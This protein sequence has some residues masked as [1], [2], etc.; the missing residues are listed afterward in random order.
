MA[1]VDNGLTPIEGE[2]SPRHSSQ[3]YS[4]QETCFC[5]RSSRNFAQR[6]E[7]EKEEIGGNAREPIA[8]ALVNST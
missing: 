8:I 4:G 6:I 1:C 2:E 3:A 7:G 5:P